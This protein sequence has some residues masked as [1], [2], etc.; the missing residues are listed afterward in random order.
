MEPRVKQNQFTVGEF[1]HFFDLDRGDLVE[2]HI[3]YVI[4]WQVSSV[5]GNSVY[6]VLE[7]GRGIRTIKVA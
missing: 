5:W 3:R 6:L 1:G 2:G 7:V 4:H